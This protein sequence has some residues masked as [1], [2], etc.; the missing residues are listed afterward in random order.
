MLDVN[1][2]YMPFALMKETLDPQLLWTLVQ[3]SV[4]FGGWRLM[5]GSSRGAGGAGEQWLMKRLYH[6]PRTDRFSSLSCEANRLARTIFEDSTSVCQQR[7]HLNT[8]KP[9]TA[10]L[11]SSCSFSIPS[12][13]IPQTFGQR[14]NAYLFLFKGNLLQLGLDKEVDAW[15]LY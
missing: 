4:S 15:L 2:I 3:L 9:T 6:V 14:Y 5:D 13:G 10:H 8:P 11:A 12:A 1:E 7:R